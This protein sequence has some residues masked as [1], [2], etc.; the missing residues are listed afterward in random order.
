MNHYSFFY[1]PFH[2]YVPQDNNRTT[3]TTNYDF[4]TYHHSNPIFNGHPKYSLSKTI[5]VHICVAR[6]VYGPDPPEGKTCCLAAGSCVVDS[7]QLSLSPLQRAAF[8]KLCLPNTALTWNLSKVGQKAWLLW[9]NGKCSNGQYL[10]Q[11]FLPS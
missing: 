6:E 10:F 5:A 11:C 2:T 8:F 9:L 7:Q 1:F 4:K 3:T